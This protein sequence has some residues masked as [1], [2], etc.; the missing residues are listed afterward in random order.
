MGGLAKKARQISFVD[1]N[2]N[3][4]ILD[5]NGLFRGENTVEKE[6]MRKI[7]ADI[8]VNVLTKRQQQVAALY[9]ADATEK[10]IR[11]VKDELN[12]GCERNTHSVIQTIKKAVAKNISRYSVECIHIVDVTDKPDLVK[13]VTVVYRKDRSQKEEQ[14]VKVYKEVYNEY[15]DTIALIQNRI[16]LINEKM[17]LPGT[18]FTER[19]SLMQ[20]KKMLEQELMDLH[21]SAHIVGKYAI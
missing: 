14:Q 9:F 13:D 15:E 8:F 7:I 19:K 6:Y 17:K 21:R 10:S 1:K 16:K 18:T 3:Y 5:L 12:N 2:N 11:Q 20:R 4:L